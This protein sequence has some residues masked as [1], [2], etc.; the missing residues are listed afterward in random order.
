[1][2]PHSFLNSPCFVSLSRVFLRLKLVNEYF[3]AQ[4]V[5]NSDIL[6]SFGTEPGMYLAS[7]SD[8]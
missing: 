5:H 8:V 4:K 3:Y 2:F 6:Q 7:Y 1:M